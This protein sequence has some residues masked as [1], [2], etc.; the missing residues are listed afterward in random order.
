[1][2]VGRIKGVANDFSLV[3]SWLVVCVIVYPFV[4]GL[5]LHVGRG[6]GGEAS[7]GRLRWFWVSSR[8]VVEGK[9]TP[10]EARARDSRVVVALSDVS[11]H[12]WISSVWSSSPRAG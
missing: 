9:V 3:P 4:G 5:G 12:I 10:A 8:L 7:V 1:M 11:V 2:E 6:F